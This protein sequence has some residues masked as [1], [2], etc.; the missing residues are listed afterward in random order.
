MRK[1]AALILEL[2]RTDSHHEKVPSLMPL[3]WETLIAL[4]EFSDLNEEVRR[5]LATTNN[6]RLK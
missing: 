1:R 4:G 2:F 6:P 5:V 3:R